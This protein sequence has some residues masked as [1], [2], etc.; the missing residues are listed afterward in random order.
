MPGIR[1]NAGQQGMAGEEGCQGGLWCQEKGDRC[2]APMESHSSPSTPITARD[3]VQSFPFGLE[4][5]EEMSSLDRGILIHLH[6][7]W[8]SIA[9]IMRGFTRD[10][11]SQY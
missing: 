10:V 11:A 1:Q 3:L 8:R 6:A 9:Q 7:A 2:L 5:L 4:I